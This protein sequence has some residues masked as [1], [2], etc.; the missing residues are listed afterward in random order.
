MEEPHQDTFPEEGYLN[1]RCT[2]RK[3]QSHSVTRHRLC[4]Q[5]KDEG[6]KTLTSRKYSQIPPRRRIPGNQDGLGKHIRL[7]AKEE[8]TGGSEAVKITFAR[9]SEQPLL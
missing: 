7:N 3:Q 9:D 4:V 2:E 5:K 6:G 1:S 8:E